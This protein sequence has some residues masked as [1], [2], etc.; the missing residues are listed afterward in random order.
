MGKILTFQTRRQKKEK[1]CFSQIISEEISHDKNRL[2]Q[3]RKF[4]K[5]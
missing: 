4:G 2:H 5:T 3:P 1:E